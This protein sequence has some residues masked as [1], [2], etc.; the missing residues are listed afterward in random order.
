MIAGYW[1]LTGANANLVPVVTNGKV[2][3]GSYKQ[4]AIFGLKTGSANV[5]I[6]PVAAP[7]LELPP[8]LH[9]LSGTVQS[10]SGQKIVLSTGSGTPVTIDA[11]GALRSAHIPS[12]GDK[13]TVVGE[14]RAEGALFAQ[15]IS[16]AKRNPALWPP[17]R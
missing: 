4:L 17:D 12:I 9:R 14:Y 3:V 10:V 2:Y 11:T 8:G 15:A 5:A 1:P 6:A 13:L 16:R 7:Q